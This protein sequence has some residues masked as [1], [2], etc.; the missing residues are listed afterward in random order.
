MHIHSSSDPALSNVCK[1]N[2]AKICPSEL[3]A[4]GVYFSVSLIEKNEIQMSDTH[5]MWSNSMHGHL[6]GCNAMV[7]SVTVKT[8]KHG[9]CL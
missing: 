4:Q 8:E 5:R 3:Y 6:T 7:K 2:N 9:K 1:G